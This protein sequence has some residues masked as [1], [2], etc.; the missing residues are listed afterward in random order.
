M[1]HNNNG[2]NNKMDNGPHLRLDLL[3]A[4]LPLENA[5]VM[6]LYCPFIDVVAVVGC[7]F[8]HVNKNHTRNLRHVI[9]KHFLNTATATATTTTTQTNAKNKKIPRRHDFLCCCVAG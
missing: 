1:D 5:V 3:K 7:C 6:V 9:C 2:N 4:R 8:D